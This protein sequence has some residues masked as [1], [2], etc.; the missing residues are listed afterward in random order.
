MIHTA[1]GRIEHSIRN[2]QEIHH[3]NRSRSPQNVK[4]VQLSSFLIICELVLHMFIGYTRLYA[5]SA[6]TI[7]ATDHQRFQGAKALF[8]SAVRLYA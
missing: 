5:T 1:S 8:H 2:T 4:P 7:N 6:Q 3:W